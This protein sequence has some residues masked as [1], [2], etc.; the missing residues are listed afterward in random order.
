[1]VD[2]LARYLNPRGTFRA[3]LA[4]PKAARNA[5]ASDA[6]ILYPDDF[7][8]AGV[9]DLAVRLL[10]RKSVSLLIIVTANPARFRALERS[11]QATSKLVVLSKPAWPWTLLAT[12]E[13]TLQHARREGSR[14][15]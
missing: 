1:V 15:C 5:M 4:L 6:V 2:G 13:S 9:L 12:I 7:A 3:V 8:A 14:S 11:R 10:N